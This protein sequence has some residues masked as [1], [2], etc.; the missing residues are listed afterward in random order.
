M[1]VNREYIDVDGHRWAYLRIGTGRPLILLHGFM[2]YAD[3]FLHMANFLKNDFE[4]IIPDLPGFGFTPKLA[5]NSYSEVVKATKKFIDKLGLSGM[6]IFGTSLGGAIAAEY[7][8]EHPEKVKKLIL[9]SPFWDKNCLTQGPV[10]KLEFLLIR[11]PDRVLNYLKTKLMFKKILNAVLKLKPGIKKIVRTYEEEIIEAVNT[12]DID[13]NRE[14]FDSLFDIDLGD[15]I[16]DLKVETVIVAGKAD[17]VIEP[18]TVRNLHHLLG[19]PTVFVKRQGHEFILKGP[20][21]MSK[22]VLGYLKHGIFVKDKNFV[23]I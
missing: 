18:P 5:N 1:A 19:C 10:E 21:E 16:K 3:Y 20:K 23:W 6:Y 17:R 2:C 14:L 11:L 9:N 7:C 22:I 4:L 12:L 13:G 15:R 8:I